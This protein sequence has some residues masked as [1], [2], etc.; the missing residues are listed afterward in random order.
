MP[1]F[2]FHGSVLSWS[3]SFP[4]CKIYVHH[5]VPNTPYHW[6]GTDNK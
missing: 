6:K 3:T 5:I 2:G 1:L 4:A